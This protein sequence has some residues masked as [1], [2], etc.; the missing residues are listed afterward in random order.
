MYLSCVYWVSRI[1]PNVKP[2]SAIFTAI[3]IV[4]Q[5]FP[6]HLGD[7][8]TR[9]PDIQRGGIFERASSL[10]FDFLIVV[11]HSQMWILNERAPFQ[12]FIAWQQLL[13]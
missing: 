7:R 2:V 3:P 5:S 12:K 11:I 1:V 10:R 8:T 6:K 9:L 13:A 4:T